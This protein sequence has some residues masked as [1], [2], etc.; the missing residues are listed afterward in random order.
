MS[1][2][3]VALIGAPTD[4]GAGTRG[5]SMG[6]EALRVAQLQAVLEAQGLAGAR[7]RQPGRPAESVAAAARTATGTCTRSP[8][9]IGWSMT[10]SIPSCWRGH[11]PILLGGDHSLAIGSISAVARHCRAHRPQAAGAVV[12]R[13]RRLQHQR[14]DAERQHPRH[15]GRLPLRLRSGGT[16]AARR[17]GA[18]HRIRPSCARSA[19]AAS[20][21]ARSGSCTRSASKYS[22]CA[23]ST[24]WACGTRSSR[25]CSVSTRTRTCTSAWTSTSSTRTSPRASARRCRAGRPIAKRSSAWR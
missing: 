1:S 3:T 17:H 11:L 9:G 25:R 20:T 12:R 10:R 18:R 2:T 8:N 4:I 24:R 19:S 23:T 7:S 15:A 22:T 16:G 5:A 14:A 6:P 13:A 21:R